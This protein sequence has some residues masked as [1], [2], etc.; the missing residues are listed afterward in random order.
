MAIVAAPRNKA[1]NVAYVRKELRTVLAQYDIIDDCIAGSVRIKAKRGKYLPRP[2]AHDES[3]ENEERYNAYLTRAVFYGVTGRTLEGFMG[4]LFSKNVVILTPPELET[5]VDDAN[6][7]GVGLEQLAKIAC[8]AV[9][10]KGRGGLFVDYPDTG[11]QQ[12]AEQ[13]IVNGFRPVMQFYEA[14]NIINWGT[15]KIGALTVP[16]LS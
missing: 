3:K 9:L 2:N 16:S 6:G 14:R 8:R 12:T 5:L 7:E 11:G 1:N 4:E 15:K 10:S 13:K